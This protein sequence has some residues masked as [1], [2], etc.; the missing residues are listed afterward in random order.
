MF[1]NFTSGDTNVPHIPQNLS[2]VNILNSFNS[3]NLKNGGKN[4]MNKHGIT[5]EH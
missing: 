4:N 1:H 2:P 3:L 5:F